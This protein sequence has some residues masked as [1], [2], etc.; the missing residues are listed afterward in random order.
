MPLR[1]LFLSTIFNSFSLKL[2][3][4]TMIGGKTEIYGFLLEKIQKSESR[5]FYLCSQRQ[6]SL[7]GSACRGELLIPPRWSFFKNLFPPAERREGGGGGREK[8]MDTA[9]E[10]SRIIL[11]RDLE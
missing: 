4:P 5:H 2:A 11:P 8:T 1:A 9:V 3:Y 6:K 7:L 10:N